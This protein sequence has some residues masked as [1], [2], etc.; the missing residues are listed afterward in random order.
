MSNATTPETEKTISFEERRDHNAPKRAF[1]AY[2]FFAYEQRD[3]VKVENFGIGFGQVGKIL[4]ER[5]KALDD[6]GREPYEAKAREDE[7][8][9]EREKASYDAEATLMG[10]RSLSFDPRSAD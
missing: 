4:G 6:K 3:T 5:W 1:T 2:M 7:A 8:R 10:I 9:Y